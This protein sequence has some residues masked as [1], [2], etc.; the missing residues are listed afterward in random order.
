MSYTV[1]TRFDFATEESTLT[2]K[3]SFKNDT[4]LG[5]QKELRREMLAALREEVEL[6][7]GEQNL[8]VEWTTTQSDFL[9]YTTVTAT[10]KV[11]AS[12]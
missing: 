12:E 4:T 1:E 8:D 10:T 11:G 9:L 6:S 2:A 5:K 7:G 3:A